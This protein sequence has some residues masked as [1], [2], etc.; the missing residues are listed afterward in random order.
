[1]TR[2]RVVVLGST[3]SIGTQAL[4]VIAANQDRFE[5]V[6]TLKFAQLCP[7]DLFGLP[8]YGFRIGGR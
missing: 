2:R 7:A 1:M 3:G 8:T 6:A 5:V 4:D